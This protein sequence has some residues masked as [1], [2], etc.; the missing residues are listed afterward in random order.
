MLPLVAVVLIILFVSAC[1]AIDIARIHVTRSEL[2]TAT[3][4]AARAEL[5]RITHPEIARLAEAKLRSLRQAGHP[6]IVYEA[7]LLFE[8]GAL[9]QHGQHEESLTVLAE[10]FP[11]GRGGGLLNCPLWLPRMM[12]RLCAEA[13]A[14]G[15]ETEYLELLIH[16]RGLVAPGADVERWPWPVRVYTLGR[17]ALV[18]DGQ[19]TQARDLQQLFEKLW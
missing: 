11:T 7:P 19:P 5:N 18:L 16:K 10:A 8:A 9:R 15:I 4:A 3:D 1:L 2:R 17:F 13:L 12:A 6:L 14:A